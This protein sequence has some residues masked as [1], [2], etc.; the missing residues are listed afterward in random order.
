MDPDESQLHYPF[1]DTLPE[2]GRT[3]EVAPGVRWL[4]IATQPNVEFRA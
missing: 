3:I 4:R 1:D 2:T